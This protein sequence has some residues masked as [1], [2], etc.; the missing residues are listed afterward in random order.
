MVCPET[1]FEAID[2]AIAEVDAA[3][4]LIARNAAMRGLL[5][6]LRATRLQDLCADED[7]RQ[8]LR[9]GTTI[10][11]QPADGELPMQLRL[12]PDGAAAWLVVQ[13]P[14]ADVEAAW[15]CARLRS[16]AELAGSLSHELANLFAAAIGVAEAYGERSTAEERHGLQ[17]V[18]DGVRRGMVLTAAIERQLRPR[19][20]DRRAVAP[21][22]V[23][24]DAAAL[25]GKSATRRNLRFTHVCP[26][27]VPDVRG[28]ATDLVAVVLQVLFLAAELEAAAVEVDVR[29]EQRRIAGGRARSCVVFVAELSGCAANTRRAVARAFAAEPGWLTVSLG[30]P[31][32]AGPLLVARQTMVRSGGDFSVDERDERLCLQF[33][34]PAAAAPRR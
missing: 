5:E 18:V 12:V 7:R 2:A 31:A 33:S 16:F 9:D 20:R 1:L 15:Q 14:R 11:V 27:G 22:A 28:D 4:G 34:L 13:V 23:L 29:Q 10:R 26:E 8:E 24:A 17:V 21:R 32:A 25:F 19:G 6:R 3:G 30:L